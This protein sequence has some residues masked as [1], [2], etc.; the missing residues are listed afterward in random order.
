[1]AFRV[2]ES[3]QGGAFLN[4]D[5]DADDCVMHVLDLDTGNLTNTRR[6]AD[7]CLFPACNPFFDPYRVRGDAVA[8]VSREAA[9]GGPA[10]GPGAGVGCLGTSPTGGCDL[11]GDG[12]ALDTV[13]H[14]FNVVSGKAQVYEVSDAFPPED[15]PPF[16]EDSV[17]EVALFTEVPES[18]L[19]VDLNEDG[20]IDDTLV[21]VF[22]GDKDGDGSFDA[23][24]NEIDNC[25]D[26]A[27]APQSDADGD[28][29]GDVACDSNPFSIL[30]GAVTCDVDGDSVVDDTDVESIFE[31]R[32]MSAR[33]S[34]PRDPDGDGTVT[35][36]DAGLCASQCTYP[37]CAPAPPESCGLLGVEVL[38]LAWLLLRRR[39]RRA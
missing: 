1:V 21:V 10:T 22:T 39:R 30:P 36:L 2:C 18:Q 16:P 19:G 11:T 33:A 4:E 12:D 27:N 15:I 29:L 38:P 28:Q 8:F 24:A 3:E 34:D 6:A 37:D 32:G 31:D 14:V 13:I 9:Q 7:L 17:D 25:Q 35:V 26:V 20:V 5:G 23:A